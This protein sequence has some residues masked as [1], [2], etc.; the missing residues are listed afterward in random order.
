M[1]FSIG[2][3]NKFRLFTDVIHNHFL[4]VYDVKVRQ[5]FELGHFIF[6]NIDPLL[7]VEH[8]SHL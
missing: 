5:G 1:K 6:Q 8:H 3:R 4:I 7:F 2:N